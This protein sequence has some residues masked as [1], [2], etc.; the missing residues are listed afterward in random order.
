MNYVFLILL[1]IALSIHLFHSWKDD[2]KKRLYTKPFLLLFI[3]LYYIFTAEKILPVLL[4][5]LITSWIG[6]I[7]L[8]PKGDKWFVTGGI[9]FLISHILFITVYIPNV[10]FTKIN[11]LLIIPL[12]LVYV[13][14][15]VLIIKAVIP[16]TP[17]D[18]LI[19]MLLYLFTNST[20]NIFALMQLISS[21]STASLIAYIGAVLFFISDCSL[22]LVRYYKKKNIIFKKH[23]TVM[24][25][26]VLGEL[27]ITQG[28]LMIK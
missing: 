26:Y 24:L 4:A 8:M 27:F 19:P 18:M 12:A 6:D 2:K 25:T 23:F 14:I 22:Y 3:I 5:A 21:Y 16:H 7:L 9:S 15:S 10:N 13:A 17:K 1:C 28:I 11:W 20:M